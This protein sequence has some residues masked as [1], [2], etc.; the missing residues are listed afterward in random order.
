[1]QF[2]EKLTELRRRRGLSQ[3][4][5]A[6]FLGVTRQSVSKWESGSVMPE[7]GKLIALSD[8]FHVTVDA[9][10]KDRLDL[11]DPDQAGHMEENRAARLEAKM[12]DLTRYMRGYSYDSKTQLFGLP[13]VSIRLTRRGFWGRDSVARGI[14]AIGNAAVGVV[15]IGAYSVGIL[16]IGAL[17]V[18]LLSLGALAAGVGA[19]GAVAVGAAAFGSCAV[20]VYAGGV[21]AVGKEIAVGVAAMGETAVGQEAEGEHVLLWGSGLTRPEVESFL[22]SCHPG[23]WQPLLDALT[24]LG[25]HI[26]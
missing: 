7:L 4:Q 1:M 20:G 19:L 23:L 24:F 6:D 25:A 21:A 5:L 22:R 12:D 15:A 2:S 8:L 3:E 16:S 14:I 13:L 26:K 11:P 10:V 17:S 9:L 18:G